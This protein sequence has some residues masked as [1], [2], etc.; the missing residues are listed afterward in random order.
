MNDLDV[1]CGQCGKSIHPARRPK[2]LSRVPAEKKIAG[3]CAGFARY[4]EMDV[5][6]MRLLWIALVLIHGVGIPAYIIAW[7]V[8]PA[9]HGPIYQSQYA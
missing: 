4:F 9:E 3:V 2:R 8:L 1:F 5:T 7:I 6:L